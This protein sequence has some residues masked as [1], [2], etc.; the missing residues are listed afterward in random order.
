[1]NIRQ[2]GFT[3]IELVIVIAIVG[4]L[5]ATALPRFVNLAGD[6]RGAKVNAALGSAKSAAAITHAA[7]L[8]NGTNPATI[9]AEGA[10][11]TMVNGYPTADASGI[12]SAG[13]IVAAE[14]YTIVGGGAAAG[15]TVTV[16]ATGA[17]T[18]AN[19]QFTY[20]SPAAAGNSPVY[21]VDLSDC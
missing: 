20:Q 13:Q 9:T 17:V 18:P 11:I 3:L 21:T 8:A 15:S 5:A 19:C 1:M 6:A 2:R 14:G 12:L 7:W 10:V 4:L 16:Q